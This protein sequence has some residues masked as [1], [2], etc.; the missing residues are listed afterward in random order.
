M[1]RVLVIGSSGAGKSVFAARLAE[2][3]GLPLVHLDALYWSPGWIK[4]PKDAWTRTVD[5]LLAR[6]AWVMDGN[7]AG[8]LDRRLAACD[9]VVFLDLPRTVCLWRAVKRRIVH[10]RRARPDM[11]AGNHERLTWQFIQWIWT[12]PAERRPGVLAKL[13][14]LGPGQRAVVLRS[15]AQIE[16]WLRSLP[17]SSPLPPSQPMR[18]DIDARPIP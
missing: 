2:R 15:P 11:R 13:A 3:T 1:R 18:H 16:T 12:Y 4:T 17:A 7:Y 9:T 10:H 14:A 5:E 8:T 6:D